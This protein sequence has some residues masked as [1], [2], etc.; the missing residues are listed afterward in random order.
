[1]TSLIFKIRVF[2][3][4]VL[5]MT[6]GSVTYAQDSYQSVLEN[7]AK[8]KRWETMCPDSVQP[9]MQMVLVSLNYAVQNPQD[10]HVDDLVKEA[11]AHIEKMKQMKGADQSDI[12]TLTGFLY[13]V[14]I[15]QN[16]AQNGQ[17]Y[18]LEVMEDY[19]KALKL[20]PNNELAKML[21]QKFF[22]GMRRM[23]GAK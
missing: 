17:R 11:E 9:K 8:L 15:V 16:P 19:E 12:Y 22:E 18:Y 6:V 13:M 23:G 4:A 7:L 1:M 5:L 2:V 3:V 20:N 10:T 21:Q 14:R